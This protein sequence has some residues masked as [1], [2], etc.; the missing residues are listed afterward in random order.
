MKPP[1]GPPHDLSNW[2]SVRRWENATRERLRRQ[3]SL[4]MHG[5]CIGLLVVMVMWGTAHLQ[6]LAGSGSLAMRYAATLGIGYLVF[7]ALLR[8]WAGQLVGE[9]SNADADPVDVLDVV[10][11]I[12][13]P[14]RGS[15][16]PGHEPRGGGDFGGGGAE[17]SFDT[18]PDAGSATGDVARGALE[19]AGGADEGAVVVIPVLLVFFVGLLA[20]FGFGSLLLLCF[21]SEVLL[22]AAV[23][24]AFGYVSARTAVR[25]LREGW[26]T[27]A[28]RLTWKPLLGALVSA[29]LLGAVLDH[30]VPQAKSL[31]DAVRIMRAQ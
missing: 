4:W 23:E 29:V 18:L 16:E 31:P 22:A 24:I 2:S 1:K 25:V 12:R 20:V 19:V 7:L 17:G 3:N 13:L 8:W 10:D 30:F 6:M 5:W 21:G 26:L 11:D 14:R 28:V 27:A 15:A 9:E